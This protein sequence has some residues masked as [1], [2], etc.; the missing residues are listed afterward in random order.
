LLVGGIRP[1]VETE[2]GSQ[3]LD[4]IVVPSRD[5]PLLVGL[6]GRKGVVWVTSTEDN[7]GSYTR[8]PVDLEAVVLLLDSLNGDGVD[9]LSG[10]SSDG[11][12]ESD[13]GDHLDVDDWLFM[14]WEMR[15]MWWDGLMSRRMTR[16]IRCGRRGKRMATYYIWAVGG[17]W[18]SD[19]VSTGHWLMSNSLAL[20]AS[21][22]EDDDDD[23][24]Q[25]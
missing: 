16:R 25:G 5:G 9:A 10:E 18:E 24:D 19:D 15:I 8:G 11:G 1:S 7:V 4:G 6:G 12:E 14:M 3:E 21:R 2:Q 17:G 23:D 22:K 20:A 13:W